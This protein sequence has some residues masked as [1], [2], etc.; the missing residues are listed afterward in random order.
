MDVP[1]AV[2]LSLVE[3]VTR[4]KVAACLKEVSAEQPAGSSESLAG[5]VQRRLAIPAESMAAARG[6]TGLALA[7]ARRAGFEPVVWQD[8]RYPPLVTEIH[9]P[10]PVLWV[11]GRYEAL[12]APAVA[13]VGARA[14]SAQALETARTLGAGLA[15]RGVVV[16]SGLARGVDSAA[17]RGALEAGGLTVGVLG[18]GGDRLYPPEHESL[19]A[20]MAQSGAVVT[21]LAPGVPPLPEHFP[22]RNRIISGLVRALVVVEAAQRSGSLITA[23]LAL[24]QGR[25]VMAVPGLAL[26]GRNRGAHALIRDG[27]KLVETVDDILEELPGQIREGAAPVDEGNLLLENN[28]TVSMRSGEPCSV[29]ELAD[30]TGLSPGVL[31][32]ALLEL[33]LAGRVRRAGGGRFVLAGRRW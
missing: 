23:R 4:S 1:E 32:A 6:R 30:R 27:A 21:E 31:L 9:D 24:E 17:H 20:E 8:G 10:P 13:L 11:R 5:E 22:L 18:S 28:L 33:E 15:S 3:G 19:A 25:E 7:D 26:S 2:A 12:T 29:D 14:A 16:V